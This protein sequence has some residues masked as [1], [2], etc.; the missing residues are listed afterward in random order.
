MPPIPLDHTPGR[1]LRLGYVSP[2]FRQHAVAL[3]AEPLLAA[4]DRTQVELFCYAEVT[5]EDDTT[6]RFRQLADHWRP[7]S[8]I[9][10]DAMAAM[11]RQDRID[12]L[13]DL[14]GHTA[15]NRLLVFARKPAPVQI[16]Y[17][18]GHGYTSGM[19][20]MDAFL[21]DDI[22]APP[23]ADALFSERLVR[24][25]RIPL[26]YRPPDDMPPVAPLLAA[27]TGVV[28]FGYFGRPERLNDNVVAVW[29]R[30]LAALPDSRLVLNSRSFAEA[31]FREVFARRFATH[32]IGGDRLVMV[33]TVPQP[34]TWAAYGAIDIAL[35][36]FP[37][38]GGTTTVEAL[39]QG[40][41]V[42][43]LAGRPTVGRFGAAILHAAGLDDWV[44]EDV[45]A[46]V[47]RAVTAASDLPALAALRAGLRARLL[48]LAIA[49]CGWV[50]A[51]GGDRVSGAVGCGGRGADVRYGR[52]IV[53]RAAARLYRPSGGIAG[54]VIPPLRW[55]WR[56]RC[57][58]DEAISRTVR[59]T[60]RTSLAGDGFAALAM[61]RRQGYQSAASKH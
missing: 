2:D 61:T 13:I 14:A 22:L 44:T 41:P 8:A 53:H 39:W 57:A 54:V 16:E 23:G 29:S 60:V 34:R 55:R 10:D 36:P 50:G 19:S 58:R 24:L 35:D 32:G 49:R 38:N 27:A 26:A 42:V 9:S 11:I 48:E 45:K 15:A 51:R 20:A 5:V 46:Y 30:I 25:R 1:R 4:H 47:V 21:A 43:T 6:A 56:Y 31:A 3:F 17:I 7:T 37:H 52:R 33:A 59:R 18:L 12:V 40:V 28:T